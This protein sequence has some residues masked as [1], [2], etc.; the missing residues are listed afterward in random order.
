MGITL[1]TQ[2]V[3]DHLVGSVSDL[4]LYS[5]LASSVTYNKLDK[6]P[7]GTRIDLDDSTGLDSDPS[8]VGFPTGYL[9]PANYFSGVAYPGMGTDGTNL[10]D[11]IVKSVTEGYQGYATLQ[12]LDDLLRPGIAALM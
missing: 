11:S 3:K 9:T 5:Q 1:N 7:A 4:Y 10:P 8:G 2:L 12:P 6:L